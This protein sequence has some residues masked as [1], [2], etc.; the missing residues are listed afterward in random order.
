MLF[1]SLAGV[2]AAL[3]LLIVA[4]Q[5]GWPPMIAAL[6]VILVYALPQLIKA[7][8]SGWSE[9]RDH[10]TIRINRGTAE[11]LLGLILVFCLIALCLL[12]AGSV[13]GD[14]F[15]IAGHFLIVALPILIILSVP[16]VCTVDSMAGRARDGYSQLGAMLLKLDWRAGIQGFKELSPGWF[17][18][19]FF[20]P[21]ML[22][23]LALSISYFSRSIAVET[24]A[25]SY[26]YAVIL[27]AIYFTDVCIASA[28]YLATFRLFGWHI[29]SCNPHPAA[30]VFTLVC[31]YPFFGPVYRSLLD[32]NDG[33]HWS[34]WLSSNP[35]MLLA[36]ASALVTL[37]FCWIWSIAPFGLRF[38][39]L[40]NRGV[41]TDGA[42]AWTKHPSYLS[43]N[44]FWWLMY[45]P[46]VSPKG[47]FEA[48]SNSLQLAAIGLIYFAR[49]KYEERHLSEEPAYIAYA[50][51]IREH[52]LFAR[53]ASTFCSLDLHRP[54]GTTTGPATRKIGKPNTPRIHDI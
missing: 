38:S 32:Y 10:A 2:A 19:A 1:A 50:N 13:G 12:V 31:Y 9:I 8:V 17:I 45:I 11:K 36:W 34:D 42:F 15:G 30:W 24:D 27:S 18:K 23:E 21:I 52:G 20:F 54:K 48:L 40:T 14:R 46:F 43:K 28:G 29:K 49:A 16:Y 5:A 22:W 41:I 51:W 47:G 6:S 3:S 26:S 7:M 33:Y 25:L 35:F 44:L 39:N 4:T 53:L 37:K